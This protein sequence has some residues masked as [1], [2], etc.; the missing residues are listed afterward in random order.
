M[1]LEAF[2]EQLEKQII[3]NK[4]GYLAICIYNAIY[5]LDLKIRNDI[6]Y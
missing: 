5:E 6:E 2:D 3:K 4:L 1:A